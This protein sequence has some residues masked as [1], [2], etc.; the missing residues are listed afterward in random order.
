M[1]LKLV[2][3]RGMAAVAVALA[4]GVLAACGGSEPPTSAGA[5]GGSSAA[6][7]TDRSFVTDMTPHHESAV[8]MAVEA[9]TRA[10]HE[11]IKTLADNIVTSQQAEIVEMADLAKEIGAKPGDSSAMEMSEGDMQMLKTGEAFDRMF[12]D[13]MIPHHQAAIKMART[14]VEK[15]QNAKVQDLAERVIAAQS[16]EIEDM[17]EWR[18][19]WYGK[20]SPAG[21]VPKES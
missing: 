9:R 5:N 20:P 10:E 12:I 1:H 7:A 18:A 13:M 8:Q 17:N 15:G 11:E 6:I 16:K 21:G 2:N 4:A 3:R 19:D 14:E